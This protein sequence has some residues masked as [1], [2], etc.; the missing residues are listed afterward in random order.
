MCVL[1]NSLKCRKEPDKKALYEVVKVSKSYKGTLHFARTIY[2]VRFAL[3]ALK[4]WG[5]FLSPKQL[6]RTWK[7]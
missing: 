2:K 5:N 4:N 3:P 6:F 1:E 7:M